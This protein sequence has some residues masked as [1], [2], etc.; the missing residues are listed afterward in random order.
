MIVSE[1]NDS[2]RWCFA[3]SKSDV[4]MIVKLARNSR[5]GVTSRIALQINCLRNDENQPSLLL[6]SFQKYTV[7]SGRAAG[8]VQRVPCGG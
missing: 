3:R 4:W 1:A 7:Y 8:A 6:L 5:L 2:V